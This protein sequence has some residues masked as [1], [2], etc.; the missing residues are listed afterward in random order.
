M[1]HKQPL[2]LPSPPVK[3]NPAACCPAWWGQPWALPRHHPWRSPRALVV[4]S[5]VP[6][7]YPPAHEETCLRKAQ[8]NSR[9]QAVPTPCP[10]Q[11]FLL[12]RGM[13]GGGGG[14]GSASSPPRGSAA[15]REPRPERARE[16][17]RPTERR[18]PRPLSGRPRGLPRRGRAAP[19][20]HG[21]ARTH[22]AGRGGGASAPGDP[23]LNAQSAGTSPLCLQSTRGGGGGPAGGARGPAPPRPARTSRPPLPAHPQQRWGTSPRA[24]HPFRQQPAN[25]PG[26]NAP[27]PGSELRGRERPPPAGSWLPTAGGATPGAQGRN[28]SHSSSSPSQTTLPASRCRAWRARGAASPARGR[29]AARGGGT[30]RPAGTPAPAGRCHRA[31]RQPSR[32][33]TG[34]RRSSAGARAAAAPAAAARLPAVFPGGRCPRRG[35]E[36]RRPFPRI[37]GRRGPGAAPSPLPA[38]GRTRTPSP[39]P[40][41]LGTALRRSFPVPSAAR[42]KRFGADGADSGPRH[43]GSQRPRRARCGACSR[44]GV[45]T[46]AA[47][48][49]LLPGC[50][51]RDG[52]GVGGGHG[53]GAEAAPAASPTDVPE[54]FLPAAGPGLSLRPFGLRS[55]LPRDSGWQV[56]GVA[57]AGDCHGHVPSRPVPPRRGTRRRGR[58]SPRPRAPG[59]PHPP[60]HPT[61]APRHGSESPSRGPR[62]TAPRRR[63][64]WRR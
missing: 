10:A 13:P 47:R 25:P 53:A 59:V 43:S 58:G 16:P 3:P 45:R 60:P 61:P 19:A 34:A 37:G 38:A 55:P 1:W 36:N 57:G 29:E 8:R 5:A 31:G 7:E 30:A 12:A 50:A 56:A 11:T 20:P 49:T 15:G 18:D 64:P 44:L 54:E 48:P 28:R 35:Q 33:V 62:G 63:L 42:P 52:T 2:V 9:A 39:A 32:P 51:R 6:R 41:P 40:A 26:P 24:L 17:N 27:R 22:L 4:A 46:R 14:G 21:P 23:S